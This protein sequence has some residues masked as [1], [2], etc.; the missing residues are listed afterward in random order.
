MPMIW[1]QSTH[2]RRVWHR[3][4]NINIIVMSF[5]P[6]THA[7]C[8]EEVKNANKVDRVSI[9]TPTQGVT[10][11]PSPYCREILFQST[12]PRRVWLLPV[13]AV[14][15]IKGFNPHTHAGCDISN[16]LYKDIPV[17]FQSTHP[18]RVWQIWRPPIYNPYNV[19]IHT[20]T[21]GVTPAHGIYH[22]QTQSFNPHTHAGCD[23]CSWYIPLANAKFQSTHPR[24]VWPLLK[25][26][27]PLLSMFQSTHPRRV[28]P[29]I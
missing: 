22:W 20:P 9:H 21:Q 19:S 12:H 18:R 27:I 16:L 4:C 29:Y 23:S 25:Q 14:T 1:F 8:D 28:W 2:P 5:N 15:L 3:R 7:G 26:F 10:I 13:I 24:R 17:E 6:H 11:P